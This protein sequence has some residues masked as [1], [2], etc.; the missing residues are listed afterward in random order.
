M[1]LMEMITGKGPS[2]FGYKSTAED[3]TRGVDLAN[4]VIVVTGCNSGIGNETVR[5]LAMRGA[6]VIATARTEEK[7]RAACAALT[8]DFVPLACELSDPRSVL[9]FVD[10]V[11][12]RGVRLDAIICNAGIMALP[13]LEQAF[14]YELQFFTNHVGHFMVVTGLVDQLSERGRVVIVSSNA[15]R[16][17]PRAGIEFDNLSGGKG[18]SP[19]Q[20][21]GQS[22]LANILFAKEL[23]RRLGDTQKTANAL[24][25]GVIRTNLSRSMSPVVR[26]ALQIAEPLA[27]KTTAQGAATQ[28]YLA[29]NPKAAGV[30]GEY[31]ADCNL[32]RPTALARDAALGKRLWEETETIV[33]RLR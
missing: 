8:G 19:W 20:A 28:C 22:K 32:S 18:Y 17:A 5:V 25:P 2:G 15:H 16:A 24:H 13:K 7:A 14:G 33:A 6:K 21:Y 3:V 30:S 26:W 27:L 23:A 11:K 1:S 9:A 31:F 12:K 29:A 4:R 10:A